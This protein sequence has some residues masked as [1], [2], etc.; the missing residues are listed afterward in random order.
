MPTEIGDAG[1]DRR[2]TIVTTAN[3]YLLTWHSSLP[4]Y[5]LSDL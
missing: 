5:V 1:E 3:N 4:C 2:A